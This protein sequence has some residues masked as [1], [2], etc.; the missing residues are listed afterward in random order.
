MTADWL[1]IV[2][3]FSAQCNTSYGKLC[4]HTAQLAMVT[5][6][7]CKS[8]LAYVRQHAKS[9][10]CIDPRGKTYVLRDDQLFNPEANVR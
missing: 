4:G 6:Q 8:S 5:E 7:Q 10:T 9:V 2:I 1:L 3:M